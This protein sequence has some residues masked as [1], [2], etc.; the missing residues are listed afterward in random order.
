MEAE[1]Q[2]QAKKDGEAI[3][4]RANAAAS[5]KTREIRLRKKADLLDQVYRMAEETIYNLPADEYIAL[6]A[7]L[8]VDAVTERLETVRTLTERYG[9]EESAAEPVSEFQI[10]LS[11]ADRETYGK[12]VLNAARAVLDSRM[13]VSPKLV[14]SEN[15]AKIP[16]G[17]VVRYGDIETCCSIPALLA[18][19]RDKTDT[20]IAALLFG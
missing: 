14:L 5:M 6:L 8:T 18:G 4:A 20:R 17:V 3:L 11:P 10:L 9:E 15:T 19:I 7:K 13:D 16:G 1:T 2:V 12:A